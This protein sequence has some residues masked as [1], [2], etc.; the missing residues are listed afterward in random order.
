MVR[1]IVGFLAVLTLAGCVTSYGY[2]TRKDFDALQSQVQQLQAQVNSGA[3]S[4][5]TAVRAS[6]AFGLAPSVRPS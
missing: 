6:P 1:L 3:A 5:L 4:V 2:V